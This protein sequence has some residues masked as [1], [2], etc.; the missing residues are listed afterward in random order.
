MDEYRIPYEQQFRQTWVGGLSGIDYDRESDHYFLICDE[1]SATSAAR[2][3]TAS[4]VTRGYTIDTILFQDMGILR[5]SRQDSFPALK[6]DPARAADPESI[7]YHPPS[8]TLVW[9]SEGDKAER[10]GQRIY[11][12]PWIYQMDI[13]GGFMDNFIL[14]ENLHMQVADRGARE[15]AALEGLS[16]SRDYRYL[17][18]SMEGPIYEDGPLA[19]A[20]D[21]GAPVRFTQFDW[22]TKKPLMQFAYP[23]DAVAHKPVPADAFNVNGVSEILNIGGHRFLVLE[24][25]FSTGTAGCVIKL[26]L[27]DFSAATNVMDFSSLL[28][29]TYTPASKRLLLDFSQLDRLIDN[30]EGIT[31]GP[32][33]PNGHYSLVLIADNNFNA[34]EPQQ[35]FLL[36][37][38][39]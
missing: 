22:V 12:N 4:I 17:W 25:S 18:A 2:F 36:E 38:I 39:P 6:K 20:A 26:Y 32:R 24:R 29:P 15:N 14:P 30:V 37:M 33:L 23:L 8:K 7:R 13:R 9:S 35:V 5:D 19:T 11:Q 10:G 16:F 31:L 34:S 3:Y 1:R 27:A 28:Q 21:A